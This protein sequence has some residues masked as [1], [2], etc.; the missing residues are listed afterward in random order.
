[1][2]KTKT[3]LLTKV[4]RKEP[5]EASK[6]FPDRECENCGLTVPNDHF[7]SNSG[8]YNGDEENTY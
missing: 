7:C 6:K 2:K 3:K 1:M 5:R 4:P 8:G